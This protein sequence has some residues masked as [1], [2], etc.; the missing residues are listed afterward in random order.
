MYYTVLLLTDD[1]VKV[2][3]SFKYIFWTVNEYIKKPFYK[4]ALES[5]TFAYV[6][7][8]EKEMWSFVLRN[9]V[10]GPDECE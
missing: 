3:K 5:S 7:E 10:S 9:M 4:D 2:I 8:E 1:Y 6:R